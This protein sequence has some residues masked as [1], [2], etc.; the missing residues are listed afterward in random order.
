MTAHRTGT[1]EEWLSARLEL[2]EAEKELTRRSDGLWG[3]YAWLGRAPLGR[4]ETGVA[5]TNT[6]DI[7]R[8][9]SVLRADGRLA[10]IWNVQQPPPGPP[11]SPPGVWSPPPSSRSPAA[12]IVPHGPVPPRTSTTATRL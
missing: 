3:M 8:R 11:W 7:E 1:G 12:E 6:K 4:N 5:T 2:L 9:V 10:L